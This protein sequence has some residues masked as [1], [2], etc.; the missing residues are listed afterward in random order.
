MNT[1]D[2][3]L[4]T[5][6]DNH[7][8]LIE[9]KRL[10]TYRDLRE[11]SARVAAELLRCG[12]QPGDRIGLLGNNSLFWVAAYLA[13]FKLGAVAVPFA[14]VHPPETIAAQ[15]AFV[16]CKVMCMERRLQRRFESALDP[17]TL[18]FITEVCVG[19]GRPPRMAR[20]AKLGCAARC[21]LHVHLWYYS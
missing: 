7:V 20:H 3:L 15:Q 4:E 14:T 21:R 12:V 11:A 18:T 1:A 8:A 16:A 2:Y 10:H 17:A 9:N 19:G 13:A 6:D 5:A